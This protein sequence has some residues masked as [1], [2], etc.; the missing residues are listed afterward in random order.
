MKT[1]RDSQS[2]QPQAATAPSN[3]KITDIDLAK[4]TEVMNK[5][6]TLLEPLIE[7]HKADET[8]TMDDIKIRWEVRAIRGS[9]ST[10]FTHLKGESTFHKMLAPS[11]IMNAPER[12]EQE[13]TDKIVLP[14][15]AIF[16]DEAQRMALEIVAEDDA[17]RDLDDR[18]DDD[19]S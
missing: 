8:M 14:M 1:N 17:A 10:P 12:A 6:L 15:V 5:A 11:M 13:I 7:F 3:K 16:Q 19:L 4:S 18:A 9:S 2:N